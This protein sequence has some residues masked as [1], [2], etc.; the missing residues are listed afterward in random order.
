MEQLIYKTLPSGQLLLHL[1]RPETPATAPRPSIVFFHGGGWANGTPGQFYPHCQHFAARGMVAVTAEYRLRGRHG[2]T[3]FESVTDGKS[4]IRWLRA[5]AAELGIAPDQIVAGGGSA[6]G[7]VAMCATLIDGFDD[8]GEDL[9]V[10]SKPAALALFNPV[11]DT[12]A[13]SLGA[14]RFSGRALEISPTH[15]IKPGLPPMIIFHGTADKT[16]PVAIVE[17]FT[18]LMTQAGN[19]CELVTFDGKG[20]AFFNYGRDNNEPFRQTVQAADQF[21]TKLGFLR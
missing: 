16:V 2:T 20:H 21:L 12:T 15:H 19:R 11:I 14:D 17:H 18:R 5:H 10:S 7:H 8:A 3:P 6:G 4:A 13:P 9:R 1:F